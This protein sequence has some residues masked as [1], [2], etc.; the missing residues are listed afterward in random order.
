MVGTTL[1]TAYE[2]ARLGMEPHLLY[3]VL[4]GEICAGLAVV[5][6]AGAS[7]G[8]RLVDIRREQKVA[9]ARF[10]AMV[11]SSRLPLAELG[12]LAAAF[13]RSVDEATLPEAVRPLLTPL[14]ELLHQ[15]RSGEIPREMMALGATELAPDAEGRIDLNR[16]HGFMVRLM[17]LGPEQMALGRE[18]KQAVNE[19]TAAMDRVSAAAYSLIASTFVDQALEASGAGPA[20][21]HLDEAWSTIARAEPSALPPLDILRE[22]ARLLT[23]A[24]REAGQV[25]TFETLGDPSSPQTFRLRGRIEQRR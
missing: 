7:I 21:H 20:T 22:S 4:E 24:H 14:R 5:S 17:E 8:K 19:M 12:P 23:E 25:A 13:W 11:E 9:S 16:A 6:L 1:L 3:R 18:L 10:N 15:Y 2:G